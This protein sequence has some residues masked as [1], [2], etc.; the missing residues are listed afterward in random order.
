[1]IRFNGTYRT[2]ITLPF[3]IILGLILALCVNVLINRLKGPIIFI[4]LLAFI[5][6]PVIGALSIKWLFI[7]DGILTL[8]L[9]NILD[10]D[11]ALIRYHH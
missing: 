5:I 3:V 1:M 2:F 7:G 8:F 9:E 4:T 11:T 6:T 10:K